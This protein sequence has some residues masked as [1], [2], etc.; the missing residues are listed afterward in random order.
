MHIRS[1]SCSDIAGRKSQNLQ[2]VN[3][4]FN[5]F[6]R[7]ICQKLNPLRPMGHRCPTNVITYIFI[8]KL[9]HLLFLGTI[10]QEKVKTCKKL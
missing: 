5:G 8:I 1:A 7:K 6:L 3:S 9:L 4:V 10:D 2:K